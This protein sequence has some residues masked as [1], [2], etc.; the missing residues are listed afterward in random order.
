[1]YGHGLR[2]IQTRFTLLV[3]FCTTVAVVA[4]SAADRSGSIA[5]PS[6]L[7]GILIGTCVVAASSVMTFLLAGRLVANIVALKATTDAVIAG[8]M[9]RPVEVDCDCEVGGLAD[10][11]R[12]MVDRLNSNLLRMNVLAHHDA[13]TGYSNRAVVEHVLATSL[14]QDA[15]PIP[16]SV[17]FMDL[18]GFKV[19][20]DTFGHSAGDELLRLVSDRIVTEAFGKTRESVDSCT[21][22]YGELCRRPPRDL[23]FSRFAGDELIAIIPNV[24]DPKIIGRYCD[25]VHKALARPFEIGNARISVGVSIGVARAPLD[26]T[27]SNQIL[28]DA[29]MAMYAA[30]ERGRGR[31]VFFD[32][33]LRERLTDRNTL[34]SE[35][36]SAI[37]NDELV[38]HYQPKL[39]TRTMELIGYEAL[40]RWQHP[41]LGLIL[42]GRFLDTAERK[43][44]MCEIGAVVFTKVIAQIK[45][46]QAQGHVVPVAVNVSPSQFRNPELC[47]R[48]REMLRT[49]RIDPRLIEIEITEHVAMEDSVAAGLKLESLRELGVKL[50]IDDFGIGYSNLTQLVNLPFDVLKVD[51]SL[52][53]DIGVSVR[54]E[55]VIE[56]LVLLAHRMGHATV[57]EGV[58]RAEQVEFL[59]RV[60]CDSL[61]GFLLSRPM[62]A[63]MLAVPP[64][65][66]DERAV[67]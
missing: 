64:S 30:K 61:Q 46:W 13:V 54:S 29:D 63:D 44:L 16:I 17:L 22:A 31:T 66:S 18:D 19:V 20:N 47:D 12:R 8:D 15:T 9:D 49:A 38:V 57:A 10:S 33:A 27:C 25:G 41:R 62:P 36:R 67:A 21:T 40:V 42:P 37:D 39:D 14:D 56:S 6:S 48:M 50:V 55:F 51:R 32:P 58:E 3:A 26:S 45:E 5:G 2:S 7:A 24:I 60:G 35:L 4:M 52:V 1:M 23:V 34:E 59:R 43:N 53:K 65:Q 28:V 11:F